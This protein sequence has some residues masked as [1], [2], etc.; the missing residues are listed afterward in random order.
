MKN[1]AKRL[2][3]ATVVLALIAAVACVMFFSAPTSKSAHAEEGGVWTPNENWVVTEDN[4]ETIY[5]YNGSFTHA[6][7]YSEDY[8]A[9]DYVS[10][11]VNLANAGSG[12]GNNLGFHFIHENGTDIFADMNMNRSVR[13]RR[14]EAW[15]GDINNYKQFKDYGDSWFNFKV[16]FFG[17]TLHVLVDGQN[18]FTWTNTVEGETLGR[19]KLSISAWACTP[20]IKNL[21]AVKKTAESEYNYSSG[22]MYSEE[23]SAGGA[24]TP[25]YTHVGALDTVTG[26]SDFAA[27]KSVSVDV[28]YKDIAD[29]VGDG[30]NNLGFVITV[31]S[32]NDAP[33]RKLFAFITR[34]NYIAIRY[35][36][37]VEQ[38][39][40][41]TANIGLPLGQDKWFNF[42]LVFIGETVHAL[43]DG[44][45]VCSYENSD[46]DNYTFAEIKVGMSSW[47]LPCR[48]KNLFTTPKSGD[49]DV[50]S[51]SAYAYS[52]EGGEGVYTHLRGD[53]DSVEKPND[54]GAYNTFSADVR[55]NNSP[56]G[57]GDGNISL[58]I[59]LNGT[60]SYMFEYNPAPSRSYA[61]L[62]FFDAG[63]AAEGIELGRK[64]I[65]IAPHETWVNLKAVY[66]R[67]YIV[68]YI[69]GER[70][71]SH[72][73]TG[74]ND[75]SQAR[76]KVSM[77]NL[78]GSAKNLKA[79]YTEKDYKGVDY[80]DLEFKKEPAAIVFDA[81]NGDIAWGEEKGEL[82]FTVT[83]ADPTIISPRIEVAEGSMYSMKL[84]VRNTFAVRLKN[85]TAANKLTL[86]YVTAV[87][88]DYDD[89]KKKTFD[90]EPNSDYKTYFFNISDVADCE[91]WKDNTS[92]KNCRHFLRGF[93]FT[94]EGA[95][96]GDIA[97]DAI[98]FEREDRLWEKAASEFSCTADKTAKTVTVSG[99]VLD[100]Y[101]GKTVTVYETS[102][103][104]YNE[105][106]SY[107]DNVKIATGKANDKGEFEITFP[108]VRDNGVSHLST[109]FLAEV[110]GVK[111][112]NSFMIEN[113]RDFTENP[114]AF[115]L[116]ALTVDVTTAP[117]NAKGDG[118]TNDNDA[119]QSAI[120]YVSA[121]GGGTVLL[122]GD[123]NDPYGRRYI[124]TQLNMKNNV[125][126]RIEEGAILWQSQ[127]FEEYAY[128]GYAPVYGHDIDIPGVPWTHAA[129]SWNLPF[130]YA[131]YVENV[132]VTGGGEIRMMDTGTQWL[133]GNSYGDSDIVRNCA[134]VIHLHVFAAYDSK[135]ID[136]SD[137]LVKR[138]NIWH[139]P[140]EDSRNIYFG[141]VRMTEVS[142]INGD[143]LSFG[144]GTQNVYI[145]RCT[146]YSNDDAIVLSGC[147]DD[148][149]G[150]TEH[151]WWKATPDRE[152][153]SGIDNI[154][155][156]RSNMY[157]GH[158]LTF[159]TWGSHGPNAENVEIHDIY[160]VDN[161]LGG[162]STS[163]GCWTD[164]PFYGESWMEGIGVSGSY[165]QW[166]KNDYSPI[167]NLYIM[168]NIY[169]DPCL[170]GTWAGNTP[171]IAPAT[172]AITDC[173]IY[174]PKGFINGSF[175]KTL[176][177]ESEKTWETRLAYWSSKVEDNGE[178]GVV[179]V[180]TKS[181][182]A[183]DTKQNV[184]IDDH[185]GY[186]KGGGEL[187]QGLFNVFGAYKFTAKVKLISGTAKLFVRN[188]VTGDV[189]AEKDLT[190]S[191]EYQT[192]E[193]E[194][195]LEH[196]ATVAIGVSHSGEET[197][198]VYIDDATLVTVK[199]PSIFDVDGDTNAFNFDTDNGFTAYNSTGKAAQVNNGILTV[200]ADDEYKIIL[201]QIGKLEE[202]DASV[203]IIISGGIGVNGGL[204]VGVG[205]VEYAADKIDAYNINVE[206]T[207]GDVYYVHLYE[208]SA[209]NGFMGR[210]A[211]SAAITLPNVGRISL[212]VVIKDN[213]LF[214]FTDG[215]DDYVLMYALPANYAGGNVGLRSQRTL[216]RFDNLSVTSP[217]Y[218]DAPGSRAELDKITALAEKFVKSAYTEASYAALESAL[219]EARAL[220]GTATQSEIDVVKA[221]VDSAIAGL[222]K[223]EPTTPDTPVTPD[224]IVKT[225]TV[226]VTEK[227]TGMTV[228]FYVMLGLFVATVAAVVTVALL[229]KRKAKK[230]HFDGTDE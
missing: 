33:E 13:V 169:T 105:L 89:V 1:T 214:A 37:N 154:S 138:G 42:K 133:D 190:A 58:S 168:N 56:A 226:T 70:V 102:I 141:N 146:L 201:D 128:D 163:V 36:D 113:W 184:D 140:C 7:E 41:S 209:E 92:L 219:N 16:V 143:G 83:G 98:T 156:N 131:N 126:L 202:V 64:S 6:I 47:G 77:W 59:G 24:T 26:T 162:T 200:P 55:L 51:A 166:E 174:S 182:Y 197:D 136:V 40:A 118:F 137:I 107:K 68:F 144:F 203:D 103:K 185:A 178:V 23:T 183:P 215:N 208:F 124:A 119:I 49:D 84:S 60:D 129:A 10:M 74:S 69:D 87:D 132:R 180:G 35:P 110:D 181:A 50:L 67:D 125:E 111:L 4:G 75:F 101:A 204:Y 170:L 193:L 100:K 34:G 66:E 172:N 97:I 5:G 229:K 211:Q 176:R 32:K 191:E 186:V 165:S 179:K 196:G 130:I 115:T 153:F 221:K 45:T 19:V 173:G 148:P 220:D 116:N 199:D 227:D 104:N 43:I 218:A 95:T 2:T 149:R 17:E 90:I 139:M 39:V 81:E 210:I 135:N 206:Y 151:S 205:E 207:T 120:D 9:Y 223:A 112:N 38:A 117:Y 216:T 108:L 18:M 195:R 22:W 147:Y 198:V 187:Y 28:N 44:R 106:L 121:Q 171:E 14:G 157:G 29:N 158:G 230:E 12:E 127:R 78:L 85:N 79:E 99:K 150:H 57:L 160:A 122:P 194:Y 54:A 30:N 167:K 11:D 109:I 82:Q 152:H 21:T 225:E 48:I 73:D 15:Q 228:G 164:N 222:V 80:L 52:E 3:V 123:K 217:Q 145:D 76:T 161:V 188:A 46:K 192:V 27:C 25:V 65:E 61:R 134:S 20:K 93:K 53:P 175:D 88:G 212:R 31:K 189:I 224:P 72:F 155:V 177:F 114:Y 159:I 63:H 8:A 62:R 71:L 96:S 213:T 91:H 94:F 142:C 86:R